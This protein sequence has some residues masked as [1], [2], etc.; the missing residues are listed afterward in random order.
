MLEDNEH[1]VFSILKTSESLENGDITPRTSVPP[2]EADPR[3]F[4]KVHDDVSKTVQKEKIQEEYKKVSRC[5]INCKN[6]QVPSVL[7]VSS[8]WEF[9]NFCHQISQLLK[10]WVFS[11]H[12]FGVLLNLSFCRGFLFGLHIA[13]VAGGKTAS[14]VLS[15]T[16]RV[17]E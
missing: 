16:L 10:N 7:A 2:A 6:V 15:M 3:F 5:K 13:H 8:G 4:D 17:R 1:T 11:C 9:W 12:Y 14:C